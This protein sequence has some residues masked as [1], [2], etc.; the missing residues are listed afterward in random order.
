MSVQGDVSKARQSWRR[1]AERRA[2]TPKGN[3]TR[4]FDAVRLVSKGSV[5]STPTGVQLSKIAKSVDSPRSE[6]MPNSPVSSVHTPNN[7]RRLSESQSLTM[8]GENA[9]LKDKIKQLNDLQTRTAQQLSDCEM[10]CGQQEDQ[11]KELKAKVMSFDVERKG[12]E[13]KQA[14]LQKE[15]DSLME[16]IHTNNDV[17]AK[18]A[19]AETD[20]ESHKSL[21][22]NKDTTIADLKKQVETLENE[23]KKVKAAHNDSVLE[24]ESLL[25]EKNSLSQ[26][27]THIQKQVEADKTQLD[28]SKQDILN[29]KTRLHQQMEETINQLQKR[30]VA[31]HEAHDSEIQ[32][33]HK[34]HERALQ[35]LS[36][37]KADEKKKAIEE[38]N[39]EHEQKFI[40]FQ[41]SVENDKKL[42][43]SETES[44]LSKATS[45]AATRLNETI[46][47]W[48]EKIKIERE[49]VEKAEKLSAETRFNCAEEI[50][51]LKA[52][53]HEEKLNELR[54]QQ[55]LFTEQEDAMRLLHNDR[56]R[57]S[58]EEHTLAIKNANTREA[59]LQKK[60]EEQCE[61]HLK[62]LSAITNDRAVAEAETQATMSEIKQE[63]GELR[64]K[65]AD[66]TEMVKTLQ[67]SC[68][69]LHES[70]MKVVTRASLQNVSL[71][72]DA[73]K[74]NKECLTL[75][76]RTEMIKSQLES[77]RSTFKQEIARLKKMVAYLEAEKQSIRTG[78]DVANHR[79][80]TLNT[81]LAESQ[82]RM[83][84]DRTL[85][86][87]IM[88]TSPEQEFMPPISPKKIMDS[89][90]QR[91]TKSMLSSPKS[92]KRNHAPPSHPAS[93]VQLKELKDKL[94]EQEQEK[95]ELEKRLTEEST[96]LSSDLN[97]LQS[98]L[99]DLMKEKDDKEKTNE[100]AV[101][102]LELELKR[103]QQAEKLLVSQLNA[104]RQINVSLRSMVAGRTDSQPIIEPDE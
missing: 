83:Q 79:V 75:I 34:S 87:S 77:D 1:I 38:V 44:K 47:E 94:Q 7:Q 5:P 76:K 17:K 78:L 85:I 95:I 36:N 61:K 91:F 31:T 28:M 98:R 6:R 59:E 62:Q 69:E 81:Q 72:S 86:N 26:T 13:D 97:M 96:T 21:S 8:M 35:E 43:E 3:S 93:A 40:E 100:N 23:M 57:Q 82:T 45:D 101:A 89:S 51:E 25:Q 90:N 64:T 27:L 58:D 15:I 14:I 73:D 12:L 32:S 50:R 55:E 71:A 60:Y 22:V 2:Q 56:I 67:T 68:D 30:L 103:K 99:V 18:L 4:L 84:A 42:W 48:E 66:L 37:D 39:K 41:E 33:L 88:N 11:I 49:I 104:E 53:S 65:N 29:E 63:N 24:T 10:K 54:K 20:I 74:A 70:A 92:K 16:V 19:V 9:M 52:K 80:T 46:T 102:S